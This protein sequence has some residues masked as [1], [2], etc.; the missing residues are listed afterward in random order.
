MSI[1][2]S[3]EKEKITLS[4]TRTYVR[5]LSCQCVPKYQRSKN[6]ASLKITKLKTQQM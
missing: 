4:N 5:I 1:H 2:L 6:I 3:L